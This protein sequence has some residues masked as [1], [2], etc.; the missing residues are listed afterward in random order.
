MNNKKLDAATFAGGCFWCTVSAFDNIKGVHSVTAGYTGGHT[1]NP[2]YEQVCSGRTGHLEAVRIEFDP[3]LISYETLLHLFFKQIDPTDDGGSFIDRGTQYR[4]AVFIHDKGQEKCV[5]ELIERI[6]RSGIFE[7]PVVTR[8]IP[9]GVFYPA[10]DYHQGYHRAH[11]ERYR[12]YRAGSGRDIFVDQHRTEY[13][14][15][16]DT[17][18]I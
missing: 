17:Q 15:L 1:E 3:D 6:D 11:P 18:K 8:I 5:R 9:A 13:E 16:F 7:R 14:K 10:E 4:S 12:Y 2:T